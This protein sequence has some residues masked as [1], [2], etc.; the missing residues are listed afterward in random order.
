MSTT[1]NTLP[2]SLVCN[3]SIFI[4]P[5][6]VAPPSFN[7]G[8]IIGPSTV[9]PTSGGVGSRL[10]QY[11]TL[12][13]MTADGFTNSMPEYIGAE[14]YW[15]QLPAASIL[16][17]GRQDLTVP[18][19]CL[20]AAQACRVGSSAWWGFGVCG[21]V[22]ADHEA[23][24]G[25]AQAQTL[26][27]MPSMYHYTTGDAA[28]LA[29]T[30]GNVMAAL[31]T[32]D[33]ERA[34]GI[35]STTQS[36]A[37]PNNIYSW[38]AALGAAMGLN[39]GLAASKFTMKFKPLVGIA[40]EPITETQVA[41]I[42]ALGGNVYTTTANVFQW[43]E[44]GTVPNGLFYDDL[45]NLDMLASD[46]QY[47]MIGG[48]VAAPSIPQD[49]PGEMV[50]IG[51]ASQACDRAVTRGFVAPGVWNGVNVLNLQT[52][53][54]LPKGYSIQ[55]QSFTT[56]SPADKALRKGMPLYIAIN[57]AGS[58]HSLLIGVYVQR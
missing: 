37:W 30:A 20:E 46:L 4:A 56:Q 2:L 52:G 16:W 12:A 42:E 34:F 26:A 19:T 40:P 27:G 11:T 25:W 3:V 58:Q 24:T 21:A 29:G 45:L 23:I 18:E 7:Q 33:Y 49:D 36:A 48:Y 15:D 43:L 6:A 35:Y 13:Q 5:I 39:T 32:L 1:G 55:A 47:S 14:I 8:L 57:G 10:R 9:I 53:D 28:V 22:A 38:A 44:Q 17:V 41:A 54:P 31:Q 50:M 51:L